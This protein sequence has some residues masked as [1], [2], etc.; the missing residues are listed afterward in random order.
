[1]QLTEWSSAL[2]VFAGIFVWFLAMVVAWR[3]LYARLPEVEPP[4]PGLPPLGAAVGQLIRNSAYLPFCAYAFVLALFVGGCPILFGMVE[5][6]YLDLS[7]GTVVLLANIRMLG[8][9][10]GFFLGGK[11]VERQGIAQNPEGGTHSWCCRGGEVFRT[12]EFHP[13]FESSF[14]AI[15]HHKMVSV[16]VGLFA[17][18]THGRPRATWISG[19][20]RRARTQE[21]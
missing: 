21:L 19:F 1:M 14:D 13:D 8:S 9:I 7:N 6:T 10:V 20:G 16:V 2:A 3:L 17:L 5:K 11:L 18:A 15:V 12:T 4:N